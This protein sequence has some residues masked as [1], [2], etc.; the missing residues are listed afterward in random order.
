MLALRNEIISDSSDDQGSSESKRSDVVTRKRRKTRH[1]KTPVCKGIDDDSDNGFHYESQ[2]GASENTDSDVN[3]D[4]GEDNDEEKP[5]DCNLD[6]T[7][8]LPEAETEAEQKIKTSIMKQDLDLSMLIWIMK[9]SVSR[10]PA[11]TQAGIIK[12]KVAY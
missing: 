7:A 9:S 1:Q 5:R 4:N 11:T 8:L 2:E 3:E 6:F 12:F 10:S